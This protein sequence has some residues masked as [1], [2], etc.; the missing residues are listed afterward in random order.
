MRGPDEGRPFTSCDWAP[1]TEKIELVDGRTIREHI[2][3]RSHIYK[4]EARE[5]GLNPSATVCAL[6]LS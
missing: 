3:E 5:A 2:R 6:R 1:N 4:I